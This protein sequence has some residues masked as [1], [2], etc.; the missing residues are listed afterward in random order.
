MDSRIAR[1]RQEAKVREQNGWGGKA[2]S[3]VAV[4]TVLAVGL[5]L[6]GLSLTTGGRLRPLLLFPA[7]GI[8]VWC[9]A[10]SAVVIRRGVDDTPE[11]AITATA[12][13]DRLS[14]RAVAEPDDA[15]AR[16]DLRDAIAD[17]D[18]AV[19]AD[20]SLGAAFAGRAD[21]RFVAGSRQ[22]L[23]QTFAVSSTDPAI[24]KD[25][26]ADSERAI[27]LGQSGDVN[28]VGSLGFYYFLAG[29]NDDAR[30]LTQ[31]AIA[32]NDRLPEL[33]FNLGVTE[34]ADGN[35]R[36]A[37]KAYDQA[38]A[39]LEKEPNLGVQEAVYAGA[40]TDLEI[41]ARAQPA[42]AKRVIELQER[43]TARE[44]ATIQHVPLGERPKGIDISD[45]KITGDGA[46]TIA[47]F[48]FDGIPKGSHVG[49]VWYHRGGADEPWT[50]PSSMTQFVDFVDDGSGHAFVR[51]QLGPCPTGGEYRIDV[52]VEGSRVS[53]AEG[54]VAV[55]LLK[56]SVAESDAAFGLSICRPP[57]WVSSTTEAGLA[58]VAPDGK[59]SLGTGTFVLDQTA[60]GATQKTA[61]EDEAITT[62]AA[63]QRAKA[64]GLKDFTFGGVQGR[65]GF[66]GTDAGKV[67]VATFLGQDGVI[68]FVIAL[69]S[70][71]DF[72]DTD[73]LLATLRFT[74][75]PVGDPGRRDP[76]P[77]GP[78]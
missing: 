27:A 73:E 59:A 16:Q 4:I 10:W 32:L 68:R 77:F 28:V 66:F 39:R 46:A 78:S 23:I 35:D 70:A 7:I 18:K 52:Y 15:A 45:V 33:W 48:S 13:G 36:A 55:D 24:L 58:F 42:K 63:A 62:L 50:Q 20:G 26:I 22:D 21:A 12:D 75:V 71:P 5:F 49:Y 34:Q 2:D 76:P 57:D 40:R 51:N 47:N 64:T 61:V 8:A 67:G 9:V 31:R 44:Q 30:N 11:V 60:G 69:S 6:V 41:L 17:Y 29:R 38:I 19:K 1:L 54:A 43:I 25:V 72:H 56:V 3:L 74:D 37:E 65:L 14:Q 53:T